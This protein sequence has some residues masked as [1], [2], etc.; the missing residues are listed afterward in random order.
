MAGTSVLR[1]RERERK[2]KKRERDSE[3]ETYSAASGNVMP[4]KDED[5]YSVYISMAVPLM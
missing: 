1:W 5:R 3:R 2:K 4:L